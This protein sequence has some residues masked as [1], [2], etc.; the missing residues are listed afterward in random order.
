MKTIMRKMFILFALSIIAVLVSGC[1]ADDSGYNS[2][3]DIE[4]R[5]DGKN[6]EKVVVYTTRD[7]D[8]TFEFPEEITKEGKLYKLTDAGYEITNCVPEQSESKVLY[9]DVEVITDGSVYSPEET[10]E[11]D[12]VTYQLQSVSKLIHSE[13]TVTSYSDYLGKQTMES[14]PQKKIVTAVNEVSGESQEVECSLMDVTQLSDG[15]WIPGE[16]NITFLAYDAYEF[17]WEGITIKNDGTENP[18]KG[19]ESELLQSAGLSVD[20]CRVDSITWDGEAY[21]DADGI[22]CRKAT[23]DIEQY[24]NYYRA[25]YSGTISSVQYEASYIG[26]VITESE[27]DALYEIRAT[28]EYEYTVPVV[29]IIVTGVIVAVAAALAVLVLYVLSKDRKKKEGRETE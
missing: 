9:T 6:I 12:G 23:A 4:I 1:G 24:V 7:K 21:T 5:N 28:A 29:K 22:I 13:Q 25:S 11:I 17:Q 19:Y 2:D 26:T 14:V 8:E 10:I 3:D 18:L 27:E 15:E 20:D 16:I